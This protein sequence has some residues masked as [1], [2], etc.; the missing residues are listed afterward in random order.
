MELSTYSTEEL[1]D[2]IDR[3]RA[4]VERRDELREAGRKQ[5]L[6]FEPWVDRQEAF[7]ARCAA[8][9]AG[10]RSKKRTK[11]VLARSQSS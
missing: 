7:A 5:S 9:L 11:Y 10:P 2:V 1:Q 4:F 6:Y 8:Q 3:A